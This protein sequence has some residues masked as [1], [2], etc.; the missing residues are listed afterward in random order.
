ME[1]SRN[2]AISGADGVAE[3]FRNSFTG[4][5]NPPVVIDNQ[6]VEGWRVLLGNHP[7]CACHLLPRCLS[8]LRILD[9]VLLVLRHLSIATECDL[10]PL[11]LRAVAAYTLAKQCHENRHK[12]MRGRATQTACRK[13]TA[14][15][16][17]IA[18]RIRDRSSFPL[19]HRSDLQPSRNLLLAQ[20]AKQAR[21]HQTIS[22]EQVNRT[23]GDHIQKRKKFPNPEHQEMLSG[24]HA[25]DGPEVQVPA[26]TFSTPL[27]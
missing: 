26:D 24:R 1:K 7:Y 11:R 18:L 22:S 17:P 2:G 20:F 25:A 21:Q 10:R 19:Q 8:G 14:R 16:R 23:K 3:L 12:P 6:K 13:G 27:T 4:F 15:S 9:P 5:L